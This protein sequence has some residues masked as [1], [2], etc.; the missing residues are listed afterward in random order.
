[1]T[2]DNDLVSRAT[3]PHCD[4]KLR[5]EIARLTR[6]RDEARAKVVVI[7]RALEDAINSPKG[8][9]PI[10]AEPFYDGFQGRVRVPADATAALNRVRAGAMREAAGIA[11]KNRD[12]SGW[13]ARDAILARADAVESGE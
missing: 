13:V 5:E 11:D 6:E 1:M 9:V 3:C 10:S 2:P 8:V 4:D 7:C 12:V